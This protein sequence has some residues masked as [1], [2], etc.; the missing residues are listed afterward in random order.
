MSRLERRLQISRESRKILIVGSY[1]VVVR[2]GHY[3]DHTLRQLLAFAHKENVGRLTVTWNRLIVCAKLLVQVR[4]GLSSL[5]KFT[6]LLFGFLGVHQWMLDFL[7][8]A[9]YDSNG[10]NCYA[11]VE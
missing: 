5:F 6:P 7:S 10:R 4:C 3:L 1:L 2:N 11:P 8:V 9:V